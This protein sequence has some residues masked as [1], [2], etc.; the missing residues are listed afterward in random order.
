MRSSLTLS[1][2]IMSCVCTAPAKAFKFPEIFVLGDSQLSFGAGKVFLDY[3]RKFDRYCGPYALMPGDV[4]K[5]SKLSVAVMGVKSTSIHSWVSRKE[6]HRKIVCKPDPKWPVNARLYGFKHRRDGTYVQ[7]GEDPSF[8]FCKKGVSPFEMMFAKRRNNPQLLYMYFMGNTISRWGNSP[9]RAKADV[10]DLMKRLPE[11]TKCIFMTTGPTY[12]RRDNDERAQ[13]QANIAKAFAEVGQKCT[14]IGSITKQTR[15][16]IE[17]NGR[18]F[19]RHKSGKV[20]DPYHLQANGTRH[21]I[22]LHREKMCR[23]V[24]KALQP[25]ATAAPS[26]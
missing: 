1:L 7:L 26:R 24:L 16:A 6:R 17:G 14:F 5:I 4:A 2:I 10:A 3:F 25:M 9:K 11:G 21:M 15:A 22:S 19:R 12:R 23:A 18:Y 20:K 8:P 13:A